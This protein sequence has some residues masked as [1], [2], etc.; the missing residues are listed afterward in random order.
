[1]TNMSL[2]AHLVLLAATARRLVEQGLVRDRGGNVSIR[3]QDQ[4]FLSPRNARLNR[5]GAADFIG[6][7]INDVN[8]WQLQ[9][10]S[11]E[12]ALHLACYRARPDIQAVFHLHS[13]NCIA[14]GCAGLPLKAVTVDVYRVLG[15]EVPLLPGAALSTQAVADAVAELIADHAAV[16]LGNHGLIVVAPDLEVAFQR[17]QLAEEAARIV[18]LAHA[19]TGTCSYLTAAQIAELE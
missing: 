9:R 7:D 1:M 13:P 6:L 4:C 11:R 15:D 14:L 5:L 12:S 8:T 18:L 2:E 10:V 19:A 17:C 16:L 3:W